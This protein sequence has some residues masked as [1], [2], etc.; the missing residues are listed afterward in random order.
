MAFKKKEEMD[1]VPESGAENLFHIELNTRI[2]DEVEGE[3][4]N[5]WKTIKHN[6]TDFID[7]CK[8][9]GT[10]LK[11]FKNPIIKVKNEDGVFVAI[12]FE[13]KTVNECMKIFEVEGNEKFIKL[14]Y[15]PSDGKKKTV[16]ATD[17]PIV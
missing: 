13:P 1:F 3:Y 9:G 15:A 8:N 12:P 5:N 2:H 17:P 16:E 10:F 4:S 7:F 11:A 6:Q 14:L